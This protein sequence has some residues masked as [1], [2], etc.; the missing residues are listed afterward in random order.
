[1]TGWMAIWA[2][3]GFVAMTLLIG[4]ADANWGY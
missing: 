3:A 2:V 4:W 1:L